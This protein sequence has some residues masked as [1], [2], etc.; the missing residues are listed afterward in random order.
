M[1]CLAPGC[2]APRKS[3]NK[4]G[5][6]PPWR[7]E[8]ASDLYQ[9]VRDFFLRS[10]PAL[11]DDRAAPVVDSRD[12]VGTGTTESYLVRRQRQQP[13]KA[14]FVPFEESDHPEAR[15]TSARMDLGEF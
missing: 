4:V 15:A 10:D 6:L 7:K 11:L 2:L 14:F 3:R 5:E 1:E 8:K 9:G 12:R 13:P